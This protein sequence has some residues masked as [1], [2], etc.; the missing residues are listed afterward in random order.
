MLYRVTGKY[1][2]GALG[3]WQAGDVIE[4]DDQTAEWVKRDCPGIIADLT[5]SLS[6]TRRGEEGERALDA[7]PGDRMVKKGR[8]R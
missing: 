2:A 4:L 1:R 6:P 3:P 5:P 7:P 8:T